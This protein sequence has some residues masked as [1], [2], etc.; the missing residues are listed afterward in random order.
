MT[1]A[2]L[3]VCLL[4][5]CAS[6]ATSTPINDWEKPAFCKDRDCPRYETVSQ[7]W[8]PERRAHVCSRSTQLGLG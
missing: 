8:L 7:A 1:G 6:A 2:A 5:F 4:A 3:F